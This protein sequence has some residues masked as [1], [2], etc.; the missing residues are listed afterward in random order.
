MAGAVDRSEAVIFIRDHDRQLFENRKAR[1]YEIA[2]E[3]DEKYGPGS[4]AV[5]IEDVYYN[6]GDKMKDKMHIVEYAS[7]AVRQAGIEPYNGKVRRGP[8]E[9][10][11]GHR[12]AILKTVGQIKGANTQA[13]PP[14]NSAS[15]T[16]AVFQHSPRYRFKTK[17]SS[18]NPPWRRIL[19][20]RR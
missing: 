19:R 12:R 4:C 16:R 9:R 14:R 20:V 18:S 11:L 5:E 17:T 13:A 15:I 8:G 6:M 2:A 3:M 10:R 1:L 7:E